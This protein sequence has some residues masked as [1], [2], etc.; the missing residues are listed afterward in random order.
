VQGFKRSWAGRRT[1]GKLSTHVFVTQQAGD[2]V[3][4]DEEVEIDNGD[5]DDVFEDV[6]E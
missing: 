1:K 6:D 5:E 2:Q 3:N 4:H